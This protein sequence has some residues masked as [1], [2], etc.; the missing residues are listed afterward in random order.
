MD[1]IQK[2]I[3]KFTRVRLRKMHLDYLAGILSIPVL[4]TAI[5]INWGNLTRSSTSQPK[6]A[7]PTPQVIIVNQKSSPSTPSATCQKNVGPVVITFPQEGQSVSDNPVC[8]TISYADSNYCSVVWS[9]SINNGPWSNYSNNSP[10]L[11]NVPNGNVSFSLRVNST[12]SNDTKTLTRNFIY[13]G[14]SPTPTIAPTVSA[15][16]SAATLR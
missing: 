3:K 9:Y 12:V 15:S 2:A 1:K 7:S 6:S 10:C 5:I 11:Y 8:I 4:I 13:A 14:V 16:S